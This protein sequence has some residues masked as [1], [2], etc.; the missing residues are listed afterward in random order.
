ML[1]VRDGP[2]RDYLAFDSSDWWT[3][4]HLS[5]R[6]DLES[7]ATWV[8]VWKAISGDDLLQKLGRPRVGL[9]ARDSLKRKREVFFRK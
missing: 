7:R 3:T 1:D 6:S 4:C 9:F 5:Y 2:G 8:W